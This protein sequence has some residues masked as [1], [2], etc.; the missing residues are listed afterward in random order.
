MP[1]IHQLR[2]QCFDC[3]G[4]ALPVHSLHSQ[5]PISTPQPPS[6]IPVSGCNKHWTLTNHW[7]HFILLALG[8]HPARSSAE[9]SASPNDSALSAVK[10]I[11]H[12]VTVVPAVHG[13]NS[14]HRKPEKIITPSK[15]IFLSVTCKLTESHSV[16]E[17]F[18]NA[19]HS[20]S[21]LLISAH[22][23]CWQS[24]ERPQTLISFHE[25][26]TPHTH[27]PPPRDSAIF[28]PKFHP[29][30]PHFVPSH[31]LKF[32][33][34]HRQAHCGELMLLELSWVISNIFHLK[35]LWDGRD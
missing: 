20:V 1:D 7:T 23:R 10:A 13:A 2:G 3:Q 32:A 17:V 29:F 35:A 33:A 4:L 8:L 9:V 27:T 26:I 11:S 24:N 21:Q 19:N 22:A 30:L 18:P 34:S 31:P 5:H 25:H 6:F 12:I 15:L 14:Q 16:L 28:W